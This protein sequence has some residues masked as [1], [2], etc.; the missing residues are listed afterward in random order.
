MSDLLQSILILFGA[1]G[2]TGIILLATVW[3]SSKAILPEDKKP[4]GEHGRRKN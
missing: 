2:F 3:A 4:R 1:L